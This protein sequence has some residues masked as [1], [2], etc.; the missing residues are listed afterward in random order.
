MSW[1]TVWFTMNKQKH[2][3]H[4][5]YFFK[6]SRVILK[7]KK[8]KLTVKINKQIK[9][10]VKSKQKNNETKNKKQKNKN[11]KI[12]L[13]SYSVL[14][15]IWDNNN[16]KHNKQIK[17]RNTT[18]ASLARSPS[19]SADAVDVR[20]DILG[21]VVVHNRVHVLNVQ[22]PDRHTRYEIMGNTTWYKTWIPLF[23]LAECCF[24]FLT[25]CNPTFH[26]IK[27]CAIN[28]HSR[29]TSNQPNNLLILNNTN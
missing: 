15:L 20:L 1:L 2:T 5:C 13:V 17:K 14:L 12:L 6:K 23:W 3:V 11:V 16:K 18:D 9:N 27:T 7:I 24:F 26:K 25:G 4:T 8:T 28:T 22:T 10:N 21:H 19:G 29:S